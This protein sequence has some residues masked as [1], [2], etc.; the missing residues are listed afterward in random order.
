MEKV[1]QLIQLNGT[2]HLLINTPGWIKGFGIEILSQ[3]TALV[4]PT[5]LIYLTN[6]LNPD[7]NETENELLSKIQYDKILKTQGCFIKSPDIVKY[8]ASYIRVYKMLSY[9]HYDCEENRFDFEPLVRK[10]PLRVSYT[11]CGN[12][13]TKLLSFNGVAAVSF[14]DLNNINHEDITICLEA[15]VI[16]LFAVPL[17]EFQTMTIELEKNKG[18][19]S[20]HENLPN[21]IIDCEKYID[22]IESEFL[23]LGL[24]HSIDESQKLLNIYTP[25]DQSLLQARFGDGEFK[26]V[27]VKGRTDM[28]MEELLP[29]VLTHKRKTSR[30]RKAK[31]IPY[32]SFSGSLGKGG[33]VLNV[34]RNLKRRGLQN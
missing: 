31:E 1:K 23:G 18:S 19:L 32:A 26:L 11:D 15:Q 10:S 3:L 14:L 21:M 28:P 16:G 27:L 17:E 4:K 7:L 33:K 20:S 2:N 24:I 5:H 22:P 9:F 34:R 25:V 6:N 29:K 12:D 8:P 30:K 13:M